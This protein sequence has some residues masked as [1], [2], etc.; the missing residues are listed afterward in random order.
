[1]DNGNLVFHSRRCGKSTEQMIEVI[2]RYNKLQQE[3]QET[4][5]REDILRQSLF[6]IREELFNYGNKSDT[7]KLYE[8]ANNAIKDTF[9]CGELGD[10]S[11]ILYDHKTDREDET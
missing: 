5:K 10:L 3:L 2:G 1:M 4:A 6:F 9:N 11:T 8:I 7:T